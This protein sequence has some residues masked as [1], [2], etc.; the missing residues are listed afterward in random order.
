MTDKIHDQTQALCSQLQKVNEAQSDDESIK[1]L[2][3]Y[4]SM[5]KESDFSLEAQAASRK[6]ELTKADKVLAPK[7]NWVTRQVNKVNKW[8][9]ERNRKRGNK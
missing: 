6:K 9:E 1:E 3:K 5:I 2:E 4:Q 7:I 8:L